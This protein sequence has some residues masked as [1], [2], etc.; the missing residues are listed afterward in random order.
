M[1]GNARVERVV[2]DAA[3][4]ELLRRLDL[5]FVVVAHHPGVAGGAA[6]TFQ[7]VAVDGGLGLA[8]AELALDLDMVEAVHEIE[9]LDL[10][11]LEFG[12][13]I[14]DQCAVSYTHLRAHETP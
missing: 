6:Q 11:A 1:G 13:A 5:P 14:G 3:E 2:P 10:R 8:L 7:R 9:A 4:T 12:R